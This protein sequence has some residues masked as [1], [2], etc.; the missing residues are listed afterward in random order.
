MS[1]HASLTSRF[2]G[3]PTIACTVLTHFQSLPDSATIRQP[4]RGVI[5]CIPAI[6]FKWPD[7]AGWFTLETGI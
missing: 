1:A 2:L 6:E 4:V 5:G 7:F 3:F